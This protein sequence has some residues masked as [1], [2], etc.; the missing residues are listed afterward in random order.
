[1]ALSRSDCAIHPAIADFEL[2]AKSGGQLVFKSF[3][4]I[5]DRKAEA[6]SSRFAKLIRQQL[7]ITDQRKTLYSLR[8]SFADPP[9]LPIGLVP[10]NIWG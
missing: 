5:Q 2:L 9:P 6:L 4:T 10:G 3:E 1:M 7:K 8:H